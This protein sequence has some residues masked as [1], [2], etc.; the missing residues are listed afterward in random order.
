MGPVLAVIYLAIDEQTLRDRLASRTSN[1]FGKAP[2]ELEA[3]LSWHKVGETDYLRLGA[4]IIDATL[5]LH[6][7]VD[8]VLEVAGKAA[9]R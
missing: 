1:D 6:D 8:K 5:P 9:D 3:I 7:V 4:A 2:T